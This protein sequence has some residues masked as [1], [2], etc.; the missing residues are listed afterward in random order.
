MS[1]TFDNATA[2][3]RAN[4]KGY[5][6]TANGSLAVTFYRPSLRERFI[7]FFREEKWVSYD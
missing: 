2:W 7:G 5:W 1:P 6:I 3:F 4:A